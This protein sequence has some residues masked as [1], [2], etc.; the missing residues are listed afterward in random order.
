MHNLHSVYIPCSQ[1]VKR[2]YIFGVVVLNFKQIG[3]FPVGFLRQIAADLHIYSFVTPRSYKNN[4]FGGIFPDIYI[5]A[6]RLS[7][8][9]TMFSSIAATDFGLKP[10]MQYFSEAS[11]R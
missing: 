4:F 7:S 6:L 9:Y 11:A 3:N 1:I 10:I 2:Y 8:K 5:V